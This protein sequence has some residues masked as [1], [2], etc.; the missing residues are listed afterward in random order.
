MNQVAQA[1]WYPLIHLTSGQ[2][3]MSSM[4]DPL[5][6]ATPVVQYKEV[7]GMLV[8]PFI[9]VLVLVTAVGLIL[10]IRYDKKQHPNH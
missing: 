4:E 7:G 5:A 1:S 10:Y 3:I 2:E 9:L 8:I 6:E